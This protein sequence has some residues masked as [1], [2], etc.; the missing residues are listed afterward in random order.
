MKQMKNRSKMYEE[1]RITN[2]FLISNEKYRLCYMPKG[3]T[4]K[5]SVQLNYHISNFGHVLNEILHLGKYDIIKVYTK[6]MYIHEDESLN[7]KFFKEIV[8]DGYSYI[9]YDL[10]LIRSSQQESYSLFC[11]LEKIQEKKE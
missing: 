11:K 10:D 6:S 2:Y 9:I 7:D 1:K 5:V 8:A 4:K 3:N